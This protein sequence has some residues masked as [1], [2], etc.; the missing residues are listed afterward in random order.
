MNQDMNFLQK[1]S[2]SGLRLTP[3]RIAISK[4]VFESERHPTAQKIYDTVRQEQPSISLATVYNVLESLAELGLVSIL[5]LMGDDN[6]HYDGN[7]TPHLHLNCTS[8]HNIIDVD[9]P[10]LAKIVGEVK[11]KTGFELFGN[12]IVYY[13]LC[14]DCQK[15]H[16]IPIA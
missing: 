14:P 16:Q 6:V 3:Q 13:G 5:G 10:S 15:S 7:V 8:C 9:S 2:Q 12:R 11:Q 4:A 1:L